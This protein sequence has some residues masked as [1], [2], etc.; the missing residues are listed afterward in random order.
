MFRRV[1]YCTQFDAF[2]AGLNG[3][4]FIYSYLRVHGFPHRRADEL[5]W[6]ALDTVGLTDAARRRVAIR[7]RSFFFSEEQ[8]SSRDRDRG[9]WLEDDT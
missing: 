5:T 2:P 9:V 3:Y 6:K 4:E 7:R 1:G 8:S